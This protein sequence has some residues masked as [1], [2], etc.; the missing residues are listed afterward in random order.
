MKISNET[1][2]GAITAIAI[3]ILILG[4]NFL[5]G[6]NLAERHDIIFSV[7][8]DVKGLQV[9]NA[10]FIK[11]FQVGK[12]AELHEK[13]NNLSGI[14]VGI[15]LNKN[16]N[17]PSNSLAIINSD[18]LGTTSLEIVMGSSSQIIKNGDTLQSTAKLGI[19][20]QVT[21]SLNPALNNIN[22]TL[23]SLDGLIQQLSATLD[24]KTQNNLQTI[25]ATLVSTTASLDKM[26]KTQSEVLGKTLNNVQTITGTIAHNSGKI[27][28]TLSNLEK[29]STGLANANIEETLRSLTKTV[30]GLEGILSSINSKKGTVGLLLNDRQLY[31]EL[32]MTNRSLTTL[33]DD[34]R[35]NPKR[36]VN[37]SVFGKKTKSG[38]ILEPIIYDSTPK[39]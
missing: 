30:N 8:P 13:D 20:T 9:S 16:I 32:R 38:P 2:V 5:K 17:V 28:T 22:K 14:V 26:I 18:L 19:M 34:L 24:P 6:R 29:T 3:V 12:I 21:N 1:K 33:L 27:D 31:D 7:F 37:I 10:V 36:Y 35:V 23:G 39:K 25:I 11:G 4:F 15:T